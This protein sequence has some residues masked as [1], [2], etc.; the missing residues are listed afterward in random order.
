[1][2]RLVDRARDGDREA[3][4]SL[5]RRFL[6]AVESVLRRAGRGVPEE[7]ARETFVRVWRG[8]R[9]VSGS[10]A[11]SGWIA[12]VARFVAHE[13]SRRREPFEGARDADPDARRERVFAA[14]RRLPA[15]E[16]EALH[17]RHLDG[18]DRIAAAERV[19]VT[20]DRLDGA[21]ARG[22]ARL[23]ELLPAE[24]DGAP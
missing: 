7:L 20:V 5:V 24:G 11:L 19:G 8:L 4:A 23:A 14:L 21:I 6:P 17:A 13:A 15:L 3:F 10:T 22:R 12:G 18:L 16:R 1:M 9:G 2:T